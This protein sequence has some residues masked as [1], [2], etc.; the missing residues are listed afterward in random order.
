MELW[1]DYNG[2]SKQLEE[3]VQVQ[4]IITTSSNP[5]LPLKSAMVS[6]RSYPDL[7]CLP[8]T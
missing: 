3:D 1:V 4:A 7:F 8:P 5:E 6:N 2:L